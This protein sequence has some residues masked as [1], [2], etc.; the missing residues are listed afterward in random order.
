MCA[1]SS[2]H[3]WLI[4]SPTNP[5]PPHGCAY[6]CVS[7]WLVRTTN[8]PTSWLRGSQRDEVSSCGYWPVALKAHHSALITVPL[9]IWVREME[10]RQICE[11]IV[12]LITGVCLCVFTFEHL[13]VC[14]GLNLFVSC[15]NLEYRTPWFC[16][17][18]TWKALRR[19]VHGEKEQWTL[20]SWA[21]IEFSHAW[22]RDAGN[23]LIWIRVIYSRSCSNNADKLIFVSPVT[24]RWRTGSNVFAYVF[25]YLSV[26]KS[27]E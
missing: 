18:K 14:L 13:G 6:G 20:K 19:C 11:I 10:D 17:A 27:Y 4:A 16:D 9:N 15:Y 7:W 22:L 23:S 5:S 21:W 12:K 3:L 2:S 24:K 26:S 1:L 25:S 8:L